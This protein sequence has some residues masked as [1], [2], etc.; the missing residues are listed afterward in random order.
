MLHFKYFTLN[1][2]INHLR[3]Q[4]RTFVPWMC[5]CVCVCVCVCL[6]V[7]VFE[8]LHT[9]PFLFQHSCTCARTRALESVCVLN[10]SRFW[11]TG[12]G[13]WAEGGGLCG[14]RGGEEGGWE[15]VEEESAF[16]RVYVSACVCFSGLGFTGGGGWSGKPRL[17]FD[18]FVLAPPCPTYASPRS[19]EK[20]ARTMCPM[21]VC[22]HVCV[23]VCTVQKKAATRAWREKT[24]KHT[25]TNIKTE[26]DGQ[27]KTGARDNAGG[28]RAHPI[29]CTHPLSY[30]LQIQKTATCQE[31]GQKKK[32]EGWPGRTW[33]TERHSDPH[34]HTAPNTQMDKKSQQK[35]RA[36]GA[37]CSSSACPLCMFSKWVVKVVALNVLTWFLEI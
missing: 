23:W 26:I 12:S 15:T 17:K 33:Q 22:V 35:E 18:M 1:K 11:Q 5:M 19:P 32:K 7:L 29:M 10:M 16:T 24:K 31:T 36:T 30:R 34:L 20:E 27:G 28:N 8:F 2:P 9:P 25:K 37:L 21:W 4:Q 6:F 13:V 3:R 14:G